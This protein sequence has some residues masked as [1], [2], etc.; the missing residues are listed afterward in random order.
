MIAPIAG[1]EAAAREDTAGDQGRGYGAHARQKHGQ[2]TFRLFDL[3]GSFHVCL[4][5][6]N[7]AL[8]VRGGFNLRS[9]AALSTGR[10]S[11]TS[12]QGL[13]WQAMVHRDTVPRMTTKA[14]VILA[15]GVG[16]RLRPLTDDRPKAL[17]SIGVETILG[18][19]VRL[20]AEHG[21]ERLVIASGYREDAIVGAL[22]NCPLEVT[23]FHN[24]EFDRTQNSV[25]LALCR[26]GPRGHELL[27]ARRRRG[28]S[29]AGARE[30]R[31]V[32]R[33]ARGGGGR[34]R[35][36]DAEAMKVAVHLG[37]IRAFGKGLSLGESAG[38]TIGIERIDESVSKTLFE[39]LDR[40]LR[41]AHEPL[42]RGRLLGAHRG[43]DP[44]RR[45]RGRRGLCPGPR[46]TTIPTS[47][48]PDPRLRRVRRARRSAPC[49]L[50][51]DGQEGTLPLS[52]QLCD[53]G[54]LTAG[55]ELARSRRDLLRLCHTVAPK[56]HCARVL[57]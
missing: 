33:A 31:S 43:S 14:A 26:H 35:K 53:L 6:R 12:W 16:S 23:F 9:G 5:S 21:V 34:R 51:R 17:V 42:L 4:S 56:Q 25:S 19:A 46:S 7:R 18:R 27:Q 36:L 45:G 41:R 38:E 57:T 10:L 32:R 55:Y 2:F 13:R 40:A 49:L 22:R 15:A 48:A 11:L 28:F 29:S 44:H 39:A 1:R 47:S 30:T 52:K 8:S 50:R 37:T 24:P 3:F 20:L 54:K